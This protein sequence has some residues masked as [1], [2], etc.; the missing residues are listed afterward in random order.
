[1]N[2]T[3][4][5]ELFKRGSLLEIYKSKATCSDRITRET[6]VEAAIQTTRGKILIELILVGSSSQLRLTRGIQVLR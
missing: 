2:M 6:R 3:Q 4:E 1:M 5:V